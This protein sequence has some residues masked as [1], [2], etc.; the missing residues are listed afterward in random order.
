MK[1][2]SGQGRPHTYLA[3][4]HASHAWMANCVAALDPNSH[5]P[6]V[7]PPGRFA[8]ISAKCVSAFAPGWPGRFAEISANC[9]SAKAPSR[10]GCFGEASAD[11]IGALYIGWHF[12]AVGSG[13][14][15]WR[16]PLREDRRSGAP[17]GCFG[18]A[19]SPHDQTK[20]VGGLANSQPGR[21]SRRPSR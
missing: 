8:E 10:W 19:G 17:V 9:V 20:R 2:A 18:A 7:S 3:K 13:G 14:G 5:A 12:S 11:C 15:Q 6:M 4:T 1:I 21:V 16:N